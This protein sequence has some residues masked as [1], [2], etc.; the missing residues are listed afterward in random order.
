M[1]AINVSPWKE[2]QYVDFHRK[3][4]LVDSKTENLKVAEK[5]C[6]NYGRFLFTFAE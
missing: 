3:Y 5:K 6:K 2:L 1:L 4:L